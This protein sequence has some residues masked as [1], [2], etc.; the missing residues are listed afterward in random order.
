MIW[1]HVIPLS[2]LTI[3]WLGLFGQCPSSTG[4]LGLWYAGSELATFLI[5]VVLTAPLA[6]ALLRLIKQ[7]REK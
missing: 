4:G 3:G 6:F 1:Y 2:L 5:Q 7:A